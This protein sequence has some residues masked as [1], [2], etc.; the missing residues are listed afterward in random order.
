MTKVVPAL[1]AKNAV[2]FQEK[3]K[4]I[5][6]LTDRYQLDV[7]DPEYVDNPTVNLQEVKPRLDLL[8]D[9]HLMSRRPAEY[10]DLVLSLRPHLVIFQFEQAEDLSLCFE[11]VQKKG[12]KVGLAI[13]PATSVDE[14]A[15]FLPRL[16]HLLVMGYPAGFAGQ[17][18]QPKVFK[19]VKQVREIAPAIELG[20]DGGVSDETIDEITKQHFDVVNVNSFL[21]NGKDVLTQY[22]RLMESLA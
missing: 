10:V 1:L 8:C 20:L 2:E 22:S 18:F 12:S 16:D 15:S 5:R 6:Q 11:R 4:I 21:F 13:N 14:V 9:V 3:I 7:I 19:K 17:E